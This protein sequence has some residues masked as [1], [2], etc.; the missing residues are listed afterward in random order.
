MCWAPE[1]KID[2]AADEIVCQ[3]RLTLFAPRNRRGLIDSFVYIAPR[4]RRTSSRRIASS[5]HMRQ[6]SLH[7]LK[8]IKQQQIY[9]EI[10]FKLFFQQKNICSQWSW[11]N[12]Q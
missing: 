8:T 9:M 3:K 2:R 4:P 10:K 1:S 5:D 11:K 12:I 7:T 6:R